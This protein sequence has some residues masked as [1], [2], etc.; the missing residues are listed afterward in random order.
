M[1]CA[2]SLIDNGEKQTS[3]HPNLAACSTHK[4]DSAQ[5]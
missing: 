5:C 4:S 3:L 1:G 2:S